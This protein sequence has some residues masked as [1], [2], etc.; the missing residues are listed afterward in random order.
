M[1]IVD[2]WML[3]MSHCLYSSQIVFIKFKL[4]MKHTLNLQLI[5]QFTWLII[6]FLINSMNLH[7]L[8][9]NPYLA[10]PII[11]KRL[12]RMIRP[13][14][15]MYQYLQ[16]LILISIKI[17]SIIYKM[18]T[19]SSSLLLSNI[20]KNILGDMSIPLMYLS[21]LQEKKEAWHLRT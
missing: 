13:I 10:L 3:N 7:P 21:K 9:L 2:L 15:N 5:S 12:E 14:T 4:R 16:I 19:F 6:A 8:I 20:G 17:N 1:I 11:V 18:G